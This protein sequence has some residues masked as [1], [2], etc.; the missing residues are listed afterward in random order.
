MAHEFLEGIAPRIVRQIVARESI[1]RVWVARLPGR[2]MRYR[3]IGSPTRHLRAFRSFRVAGLA[4]AETPAG[5][6][7]I[8][9][10]LP[11]YEPV[12]WTEVS[13]AKARTIARRLADERGAVVHL[14]LFDEPDRIAWEPTANR[15]D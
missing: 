3:L 1:R 5:R 7:R 4:C 15:A 2:S 10:G 11:A 12:L 13:I 9:Q 6:D 8:A 14:A